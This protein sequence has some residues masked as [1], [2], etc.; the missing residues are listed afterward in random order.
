MMMIAALKA[1]KIVW[2]KEE[3]N[4]THRRLF[5]VLVDGTDLKV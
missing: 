1:I 3:Y 4:N 2:S 5:I